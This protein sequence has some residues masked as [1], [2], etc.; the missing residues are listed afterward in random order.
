MA[1]LKLCSI[2]GET[3][4]N[5]NRIAAHVTNLEPLNYDNVIDRIDG[6][7]NYAY[8]YNPNSTLYYAA[9]FQDRR[10]CTYHTNSQGFACPGYPSQTQ[11]SSFYVKFSGIDQFGNLFE[12]FAPTFCRATATCV[13]GYL[14]NG[15]CLCESY[16]E[17]ST[18]E[19]RICLYGGTPTPGGTCN[20]LPEF[21]GQI[22]LN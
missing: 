5:N 22:C 6:H 1:I 7:L 8:I 12:R 16:W 20:C 9:T 21:G 3:Q 2:L 10:I 19:Q 13:N 14:Y 18:C 11:K 4:S 17:G 15:A